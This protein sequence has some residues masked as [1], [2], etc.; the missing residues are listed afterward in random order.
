M[1]REEFEQ[2]VD[3]IKELMLDFYLIKDKAARKS[4]EE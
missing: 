2:E 1:T 3:D 4:L